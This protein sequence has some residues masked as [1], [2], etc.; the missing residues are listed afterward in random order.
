MSK[1]IKKQ[2]SKYIIFLLITICI[3]I[4]LFLL[5]L[6][7]TK[8]KYYQKSAFISASG[9]PDQTVQVC[10]VNPGDV[11]GMCSNYKACCSSSGSTNS[12][13]CTHPVV[14]QCKTSYDTCMNDTNNLKIYTPEQLSEKCTAQNSQCCTSYNNITIDSANFNDP[15]IQEQKDNIICTMNIT[16][17]MNI[18]QKCMELC[19]T[20]PNC[21]AFSILQTSLAPVGCNLFS[22]ISPPLIDP[23][24][25]N[26]SSGKKPNYYVKK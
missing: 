8:Y 7:N 5:Y 26:S 24:G 22:E 17:N 1:S 3:L 15:I 18:T 9:N 25:G 14:Q 20:N 11:V 12:C 10:S 13:I 6:L 19:Q 21:K 4:L 16:N 2:N 23:L